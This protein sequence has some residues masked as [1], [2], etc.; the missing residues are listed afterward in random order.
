MRPGFRPYVPVE[1]EAR[2]Q[3]MNYNFKT[4]EWILMAQDV[5][6]SSANER[7]ERLMPCYPKFRDVTNDKRINKTCHECAKAPEYNIMVRSS[8]GKAFNMNAK[9]FGVSC[10]N[11]YNGVIP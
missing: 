7:V 4:R 5:K 3:D 6:N 11:K 9:I 1:L 8:S 10:S 2:M